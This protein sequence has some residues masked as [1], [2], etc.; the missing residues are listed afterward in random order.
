MKKRKLSTNE[1]IG[2]HLKKL[3]GFHV[4]NVELRRKGY[5][6]AVKELNKFD[7]NYEKIKTEIHQ[8]IVSRNERSSTRKK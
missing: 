8:S 7:N 5:A 3:R 2:I 1:I 4:D 6:E